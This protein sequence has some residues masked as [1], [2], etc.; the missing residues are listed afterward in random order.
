MA[1]LRTLLSA[2]AALAALAT[3][4]QALAA[5]PEATVPQ[6]S[7]ELPQ[8]GLEDI[9]VT[10]RKR[11][12]STQNVPIAITAYSSEMIA[13]R[14]LTSLEKIAAVTPSL[15]I[16]RAASGSGAIM[17]LRG[18]GSNSSSIGI[19]SSIATV[20]DGVYF[21]QGRILNEGFFDLAG[22]EVLKGPQALFFGKNATAGVISIKT[23]NPTDDLEIIA[24]AGYE[25][26]SKDLS[27]ELVVSSPLTDTLGIRVALKASHMFGGYFTNLAGLTTYRTTP[28]SFAPTPTT[29]PVNIRDQVPSDRDAGQIHEKV[30]RITLEWKPTDRLTTSLKLSGNINNNNNPAYNYVLVNCPT[31]FS[32]LNP[33]VPCRRDFNIYT[34][35][36][37]AGIGD[38]TLFGGD[39]TLRNEY[40]AWQITHNL[41]YRSDNIL[42]T[43]V[44]N[45]NQNKN[46]YVCDCDFTVS[47]VGNSYGTEIARWHAFS[48]EGRALTTYDGPINVMLGGLYQKTRRK[49]DSSAIGAGRENLDVPLERRFL[50][51]IKDSATD[52]ETI[53]VF[54]QAIWKIVPRIELTAGLRYTHETKESY[55]RHAYK[56][57]LNANFDIT[58]LITANQKFD[59]WSPDATLTWRV[60]DDVTIYGGYRTAYKSGGFS[61]SGI[62]SPVGTVEDFTFDPE[63]VKGFEGGIKTTLFDR[64]LRANLA[65]YSYRYN[66]LQVDFFN[67]TIFAFST[68]NAGS[69]KT[70]GVELDLEFAPRAVHGLTM[71]GSLNYNKANY[72]SFENAPCYAGQSTLLGCAIGPERPFQD[73]TGLKTADAPEWTG[74]AGISYDTDLG[75]AFRLGLS[76]DGRFSSSYIASAFG[77][78]AS[79]QASYATLDA[80]LRL[81]TADEHWE[82]ALIGKNLTNKLYINGVFDGPLTG[83]GTGTPAGVLADQVGFAGM[84]RTVQL[85]LTWHY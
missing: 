63:T 13:K 4:G 62:L 85:K 8:G 57:P 55:F 23:A 64:Q 84:P 59:N 82:I 69:A 5:Q 75:D 32:G 41:E 54:G 74:S 40:Q 1:N 2:G 39:G 76:V 80:G 48:W 47:N 24:R 10:A 44:A 20:V 65:L 53:A 60:T 43:S 81:Q 68:L 6:A 7:E 46:R 22:V 26:N 79:A 51:N 49:Y 61:N 11:A 19:E 30:G 28:M 58:R 42:F 78:Q 83:R 70:R 21:G 52:G 73:L 15:N 56:H 38:V 9:V 36:F 37:P 67:S 71:R 45:Y 18:I 50:T 12:E 72:G 35:N 16:V 66:N 77:N 27:G 34:S 33:S 25:F 17:V 14:D 29:G 31:G 3:S